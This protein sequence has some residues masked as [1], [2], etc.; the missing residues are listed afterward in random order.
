MKKMMM[1]ALFLLAGYSNSAYADSPDSVQICGWAYIDSLQV[2]GETVARPYDSLLPSIFDTTGIRVHYTTSGG[3]ASSLPYARAV[4]GAAVESWRIQVDTLGWISPK[5][6]SG[7]GGDNRV[8]IYIKD[9]LGTGVQGLTLSDKQPG[10]ASSSYII[11]WKGIS[12]AGMRRLTVAHEFNHVCQKSYNQDLQ[13][14]DSWF[15]ESSAQLMGQFTFPD[16][17]FA[18]LT[19]HQAPITGLYERLNSTIPGDDFQYGQ[20]VWFEFLN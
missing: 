11:I 6:D 12:N 15:R 16:T 7:L 4:G 10:R 17:N 2:L 8:D 1:I 13:T 20:W 14:K 3:H 5:S 18:F 19:Q 9:S